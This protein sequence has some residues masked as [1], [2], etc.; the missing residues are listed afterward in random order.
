MT[1]LCSLLPM[2]RSHSVPYGHNYYGQIPETLLRSYDEEPLIVW[3]GMNVTITPGHL[4]TNN[5]R[6]VKVI[7]NY[8]SQPG[9]Y[10]DKYFKFFGGSK[11]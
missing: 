11:L 2:R 9:K 6:E 10:R 4:I 3:G 8:G 7:V 1:H 5:T